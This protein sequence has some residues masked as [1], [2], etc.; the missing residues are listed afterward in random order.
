MKTIA[1]YFQNDPVKPLVYGEAEVD[2]R[3][4]RRLRGEDER[5]CQYFF[6]QIERKDHE[7]VTGYLRI[8]EQKELRFT[9]KRSHRR[10][11]LDLDSGLCGGYTEQSDGCP[12][13]RLPSSPVA[14]ILLPA[15][16]SAVKVG[17]EVHLCRAY[18]SRAASRSRSRVY[19]CSMLK[20]FFVPQ[21]EEETYRN[22]A[23]TNI[24]ALFPSGNAPT[25]FVRLRISRFIRSI[26]LFER[27]FIQSSCGNR[28]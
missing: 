21:S 6:A 28:V 20:Y 15:A 1:T 22:R 5:L 27:I 14:E 13:P 3:A 9:Y 25:A 11:R 12:T 16:R 4:R 24:S 18:D 7:R 23:H 2:D 10:R 17:G 8:P 19:R 26:P